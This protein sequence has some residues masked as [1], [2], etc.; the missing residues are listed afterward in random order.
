MITAN[1]PWLK[2][3]PKE[4]PPN[5]GYPVMPLDEILEK[6]ARENP[7]KIALSCFENEIS[8]AELNLLSAKFAAALK[9]L[10]VKKGDRV[11]IFLP[12]IPQYVI[13]YF[14]IL[15]AGAILT[16]VSP[17][18]R[19]REVEHQLR[20]SETETIITLD[21]N[22]SIIKNVSRKIKLRCVDRDY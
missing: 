6:T 10:G 18:Y 5:I 14:G 4:V 11:A 8:Y 15:K 16:A 22:F 19:E 3:Y 7:A 21:T 20:D 9:G 13:A 12:N 17:M 1:K 2:S